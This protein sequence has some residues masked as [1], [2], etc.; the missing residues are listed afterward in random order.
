MNEKIYDTEVKK[1]S[2]L[3]RKKFEINEELEELE[4]MSETPND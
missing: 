4:E 2:E 1:Y 3:E